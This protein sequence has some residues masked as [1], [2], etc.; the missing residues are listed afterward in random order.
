MI[1]Q[2]TLQFQNSIIELENEKHYRASMFACKSRLNNMVKQL[3]RTVNVL[4]LVGDEGRGK[5]R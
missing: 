3:R 5:L 2:T 4:A 1:F